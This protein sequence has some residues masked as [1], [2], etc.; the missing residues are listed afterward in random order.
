M[1]AFPVG[2][3]TLDNRPSSL[4]VRRSGQ[5]TYP[6]TM[7]STTTA[8][9]WQMTSTRVRQP[10]FPMQLKPQLWK[11]HGD[12]V[13]GAQLR[14]SAYHRV[15][16]A[17]IWAPCRRHWR[18]RRAILIRQDDTKY[19][20]RQFGFPCHRECQLRRLTLTINTLLWLLHNVE[21]YN[22]QGG[23]CPS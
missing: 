21:K 18:R 1:N 17:M 10:P 12:S 4:S 15:H 6:T 19:R 14:K 5:Y 8:F 23:R 13:S 22:M 11:K 2:S 16:A 20:S 3:L 7:G 9:A